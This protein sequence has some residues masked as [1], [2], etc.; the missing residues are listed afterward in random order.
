MVG[1]TA[2]APVRPVPAFAQAWLP[3]VVLVA[4]RVSIAAWRRRA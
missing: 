4:V 2:A 3:V 1:A